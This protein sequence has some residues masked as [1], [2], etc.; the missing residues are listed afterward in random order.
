MKEDMKQDRKLIFFLVLILS[1]IFF[2]GFGG[3]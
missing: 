2:P 1:W 3:G